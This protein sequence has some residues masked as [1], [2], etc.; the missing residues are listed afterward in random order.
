MTRGLISNAAR[1][2]Q[3]FDFRGMIFER[4]ISPTDIDA[5]LDFGGEELVIVEYKVVG[6][7]V[8]YGQ[9]RAIE[10]LI[11]NCNKA[12]NRGIAII[13]NHN[14]NPGDVINGAECVVAE[15][16]Q[17]AGWYKPKKEI[18]VRRFVDEWRVPF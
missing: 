1:Y 9:R 15:Y 17:S 11:D 3:V 7:S 16:Y 8:P 12:K 13:A 2:K 18:T 14:S 4:K 10:V 6:V 5:I